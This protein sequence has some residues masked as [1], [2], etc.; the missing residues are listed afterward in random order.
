MS[1]NGNTPSDPWILAIAQPNVELAV[2]ERLERRGFDHHVFRIRTRRVQR[3]RTI[4][5]E[6]PAFPR[7]VFARIPDERWGEFFEQIEGV[8]GY[9]RASRGGGPAHIPNAVVDALLAR[10]PDGIL[11]PPEVPCPFR[12]GER[13]IVRG[14]GLAAGYEGR[15][16]HALDGVHAVIEQPWLGRWVTVTVRLDDLERLL[17][18]PRKRKRR[19]HRPKRRR[20][21]SQAPGAPP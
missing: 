11:Q 15:F 20:N 14:R 16:Q 1:S 5:V 3:G 19:H 8:A 7:Y 6:L 12:P 17:P 10:A 2:S 13:V 9:V 18:V 21:G 4:D